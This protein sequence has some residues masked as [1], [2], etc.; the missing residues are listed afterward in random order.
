[1]TKVRIQV[2]RMFY[3]QGSALLHLDSLALSADILRPRVKAY[4]TS[5]VPA[6]EYT[7][8]AP[9]PNF[10]STFN[11]CGLKFLLIN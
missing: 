5:Q 2:N 11:H 9:A 1:M 4:P 3:Y 8:G 6:W 7:E 10:F